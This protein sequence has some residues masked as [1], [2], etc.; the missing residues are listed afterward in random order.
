MNASDGSRRLVEPAPDNKLR[1]V[2]KDGGLI[3]V[4][5]AE[6]Y[7]LA[8]ALSLAAADLAAKRSIGEGDNRS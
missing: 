8:A 5:L 1:I 4:E 6:V 3:V 7:G 2:R